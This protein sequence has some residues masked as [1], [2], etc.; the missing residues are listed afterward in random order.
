MRRK[1]FRGNVMKQDEDAYH[2]LC[3]YTLTRGDAAFI[4]QHVVDAYAAQHANE[5]TKPIT[6]TFALIGLYLLAEHGTSGR[7]VQRVHM[8]LGRQ[9]HGWPVFGLPKDRGA[10]TAIDVL[11]A[12]V[13]SE[14]DRAIHDWCRSV[15]TAFSTNRDTVAQ[16]LKQHGVIR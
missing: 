11:G 2:Q 14:R 9:K 1:V 13:G 16:L 4:H 8:Q 15:W 7:Q 6:I 10:M 3:A 5:R 12:P